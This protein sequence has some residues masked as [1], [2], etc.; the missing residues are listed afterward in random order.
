MNSDLPIDSGVYSIVSMKQL[1]SLETWGIEQLY[2]FG[3]LGEVK[4]AGGS[5]ASW[6][7]GGWTPLPIDLSEKESFKFRVKVR[8]R[9][10]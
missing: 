2:C 10:G 7:L 3:L 8:C 9:D 1:A 4:G 5:T 6:L